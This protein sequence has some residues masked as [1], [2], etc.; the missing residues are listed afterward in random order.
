MK[1]QYE[2]TSANILGLTV[3]TN[4]PQGGDAG[5]GGVT[6]VTIGDLAGTCWH[7]EWSGKGGEPDNGFEQHLRI[8]AYGDCEAVTLATALELAAKEIRFQLACNGKT[9]GDAMWERTGDGAR[10]L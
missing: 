4:C 6:E 5:H 1:Y 10:G 2:I 7:A 8:V 9:R 3:K